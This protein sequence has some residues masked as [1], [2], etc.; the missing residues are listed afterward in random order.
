[1]KDVPVEFP[2]GLYL[3]VIMQREE[4][5]DAFVSNQYDNV[6]VLPEGAIVGTASLRRQCQLLALRPD[7]QIRT[8]RGNV[9]TR[10]G[11]LD[12]GEFSYNF[13]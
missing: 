5:F 12:S 8:L 11:K 4:P 3:P 1:M 7:L 13:V 2:D 10:L 6:H 9:G